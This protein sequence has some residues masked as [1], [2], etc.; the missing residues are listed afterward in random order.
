MIIVKTPLRISFFGGGSDFKDYYEKY[1][2]Q[3]LS[4]AI[5]KFSY[6]I[7]RDL[8][9]YFSYKNQLNYS[10][11]ERFNSPDEVKHPLVREAMKH[12]GIDGVQLVYYA[13]LPA[14]SGIGSSSS[15]SVGL[16]NAFHTMK[17]DIITKQQ[18]AEEAIYLERVL[19]REA[20]GV[21][22]QIAAAYGG[23][24]HITF[25]KN[26]FSV[27][28]VDLTEKRLFELNENL[29][30]FFTGT[31]RIS[32]KVSEIQQQ[33][34]GVN[35]ST[36]KEMCSL[37]DEAI[38]V[39]KSDGSLSDFGRLLDES[40][41][42]KKTLADRVSNLS[43]DEIYE[44]AVDA[45]ALGGKLSGAGEGGFMFFYVEKEK[46]ESVKQALKDLIYVPFKFEK[47]GSK[48]IYNGNDF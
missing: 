34:I 11:I 15:F 17:N 36:I 9:P 10:V 19:C 32:H 46:Q 39:L 21:Q 3:V 23:F 29:M 13:D 44:K 31:Q 5:D 2:G 6:V 35:V 45:G 25:D 33:N 48:V 16:V 30:L 18:L 43:I 22:D 40:W 7:V 42:M 47:F 14:R 41:K 37:A 38:K 1:G 27:N 20:G 4:T 26:G 8:P 24:N 12:Y 28:P